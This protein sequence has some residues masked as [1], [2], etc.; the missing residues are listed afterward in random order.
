MKDPIADYEIDRLGGE[1]SS[2]HSLFG[3]PLAGGAPIDRAWSLLA[4]VEVWFEAVE[5][6]EVQRRA[7]VLDT[8]ERQ[9]AIGRLTETLTRYPQSQAMRV[10]INAAR[11]APVNVA[12]AATPSR[13]RPTSGTRT[14]D[15]VA[16]DETGRVLEHAVLAV[17]LASELDPADVALLAAPV[18]SVV[19]AVGEKSHARAGAPAPPP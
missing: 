2:H 1:R 17:V 11:T 16:R 9:A 15:R 7:R 12:P 18:L 6:H 10:L 13:G 5:W 3:V 8:P 4:R 19:R 14:L